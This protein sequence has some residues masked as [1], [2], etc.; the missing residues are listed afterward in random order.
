M[1]RDLTS[2]FITEINASQLA[3]AIFVICYFDSGTTYNWT[4]YGDITWNGNTYQ[5][6]GE[7][8]SF[9]KMEESKS[10]KANGTVMSLSGVKTSLITIALQE[11]YQGRLSEVYFAVLDTTTGAVIPDPYLIF[12]GYMDEMEHSLDG[13]DTAVLSVTVENELIDLFRTIN[14]NYTSEDQKTVY[15]NDLGLD[16]IPKLQDDEI[17]WKEK[18]K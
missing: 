18:A 4:G 10:I 7:N 9:G 5:G 13:S 11:N 3:A 2:A 1:A 15:P 16:F 14:S 8:L 17:V 6:V 12:S